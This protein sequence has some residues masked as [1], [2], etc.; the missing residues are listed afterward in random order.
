MRA[1]ASSV[2]K[3]GKSETGQIASSLTIFTDVAELQPVPTSRGR[4]RLL[5][6]V[7]LLSVILSLVIALVWPSG[8]FTNTLAQLLPTMG[9]S[10]P[11]I[12]TS[13]RP[14]AHVTGENNT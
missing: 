7:L 9:G 14:Y 5:G 6:L 1:V 13:D 12:L 4:R 3:Q 8:I 11:P 2:E 10:L